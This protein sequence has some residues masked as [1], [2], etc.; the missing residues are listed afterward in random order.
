MASRWTFV[1]FALVAMGG[2]AGSLV[3]GLGAFL[4]AN[5][6]T[7]VVLALAGQYAGHLVV[8]W[9]V[10]RSRGLGPSSL[11]FELRPSDGLYLGLGI[12][13]Q[14]ALALLF[15]P[16][17]EILLPEGRNAQ[18]VATVLQDLTSSWARIAAVVMTTLLAPVVEELMFRGVLLRS[19]EDRSR[20]FVLVVTSVVFALFHLIGVATVGAGVLVFIQIFLVGLL[21]GHLTL[22]HGRLGPAI[23]VHAGFNLLAAIVLLLPPELLEELERAAA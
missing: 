10:G 20:R 2:V 8:L 9:L 7:F 21:L 3:F 5:G 18:D 4:F 15:Q 19:V 23:F 16:L 22:R 12:V 14:I 17:S 11:G 13:L 1:D 6:E